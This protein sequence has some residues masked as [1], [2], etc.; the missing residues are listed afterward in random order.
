MRLENTSRIALG[1]A[2]LT[3]CVVSLAMALGFVESKRNAASKLQL[4]TAETLAVQLSSAI[5]VGNGKIDVRTIDRL[6]AST[7]GIKSLGL[8]RTD[9]RLLAASAEHEANWQ[10]ITNG[11]HD[12]KNSAVIPLF[13]GDTKWGV[14]EVV[15]DEPVTR[16]LAADWPV[17]AF[18]GATS[19]VAFVIYIRRTMRLL[20]PSSVVPAR[21]RAMLDTL[22]E[23]AAIIDPRG[24]F[25]LIN[26]SFAK[27]VSVEIT[28]LLGKSVDTF[29]WRF[30]KDAPA[31]WLA[32]LRGETMRG[33]TMQ[34]GALGGVKTLVANASPIFGNGTEVRGALITLDDVTPIQEKNDQLT[35]MVQ[36]LNEAQDRVRRQ[37]EELQSLATRD[38]LTGVLNR[39]AFHDQ[40]TLHVGLCAR[41]GCVMSAIMVDV[42][43]FKSVNDKHGHAMGDRVLQAVATR[44]S[45]AVRSSDI[46]CRYGGEEFCVLLPQSDIDSAQQVAETIRQA[47]RAETVEGLPITA[48]LGVSSTRLAEGAGQLMI[49]QADEALYTSKHNGR[50]RVTIFDAATMTVGSKHAK[51]AEGST[52][53]QT[54]R[55]VSPVPMQV[56]KALVGMLDYRDPGT[57]DHSRRVSEYCVRVA[58]D[59]LSAGE[60]LQLEVAALLHDIGK[61]GV[62]DS[63][64]LKPAA[65]T[66]EERVIID[67]HATIGTE[68]V[69]ATF[70]DRPLTKIVQEHHRRYSD[71]GLLGESIG[72]TTRFSTCLLSIAD[73]YDAMTSHRVYRPA[74]SQEAA[75][76]EL[77]RC[78]GT[79]FDPEIVER[80]LE[81]V[82]QPAGA[83][84]VEES[85]S[86][87][88]RVGTEI[89]RLA[90]AVQ[91]RD[92]AGAL[93]IAT[94][95][96]LVA[97]S[98][99]ESGISSTAAELVQILDTQ[100]E[101]S[102]CLQRVN[103]LL[104]VVAGK[105]NASRP[106]VAA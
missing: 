43:H 13:N 86:R 27:L 4:R 84:E 35:Q 56:V 102:D 90:S 71:F 6:L 45:N 66:D 15:F 106:A 29:D 103:D 54:P 44:I 41:H 47:L 8:R 39:R 85:E 96:S 33:V 87:K 78:A 75:C 83:R 81:V 52:S 82:K 30:E 17:L 22:T 101:L 104:E 14:I 26:G 12:S 64:L 99:G 57:A 2:L 63:V 31:P 61:V 48:S 74:M 68:I 80:F 72:E 9:G 60:R 7:P 95:L 24:Q 97:T 38:A 46:V 11:R 21:V 73:A 93:A 32:A 3:I 40:L 70:G 65:L 5:S 77:R 25:M 67:R 19:L 42:D 69:L 53:P 94:H 10:P 16:S 36:Q 98:V 92:F 58:G 59:K 62:P 28:Q 20:D 34:L 76:A 79:Q 51:K 100:P 23:G 49:E 88:L 105:S 55:E 37:N 1:L 18:V 50:D 91:R 89:E